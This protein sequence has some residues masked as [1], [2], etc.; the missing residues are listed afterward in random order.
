MSQVIMCY[1]SRKCF[2]DLV[3]WFC[4]ALREN[5]NNMRHYMVNVEGC[6]NHLESQ[7]QK[8]F[9]EIFKTILDRLSNTDNEEEAMSLLTAM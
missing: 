5:S 9:F 7:I 1:M 8:R 4:A 6:G 3:N 2:S